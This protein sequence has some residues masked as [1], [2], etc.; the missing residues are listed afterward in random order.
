MWWV[1]EDVSFE[2]WKLELIVQQRTTEFLHVWNL[3]LRKKTSVLPYFG[4]STILC[5]Q[6]L[7]VKTLLF[8]VYI[9]QMHYFLSK[10]THHYYNEQVIKYFSQFISGAYTTLDCCCHS[11]VTQRV[12]SQPI[13]TYIHDL[14]HCFSDHARCHGKVDWSHTFGKKMRNKFLW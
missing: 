13:H 14:S 6:K 2:F 4:T 8:S 3:F 10:I 12:N 5:P 11:S 9:Q 1:T 7:V